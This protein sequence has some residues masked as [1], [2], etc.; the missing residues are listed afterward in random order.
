MQTVVL[1]T[2]V[3]GYK[4][5]NNNNNNYNNSVQQLNIDRQLESLFNKRTV[6]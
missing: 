1:N 6:G 3:D 4:I 5:D 2:E